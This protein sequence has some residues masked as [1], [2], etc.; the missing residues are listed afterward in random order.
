MREEA[1]KDQRHP[2]WCV[3]ASVFSAFI[4][5]CPLSHA[6]ALAGQIV[7]NPDNPAWLKYHQGSPFFM[8]GPGDP[9]GFLYRGTRNPDGTRTGDQMTLIDK[10]KGTGANAIYLMAVRSHGGDGDATH[11]PFVNNDPARGINM[12]VLDQWETWFTEMD[13]HGIVIFLFFYDDAA[14]IWDTGDTVGSTEEHFIHTLVNRF[15]HHRHLIWVVAEEYEE[16]YSAKR[17]S[18]IAAETRAA[19]DYDHPIAVHKLSGLDFSEFAGDPNI[20]QF[21]IQYNVS[22]PAALHNGMVTAWTNAAGRY[23]LNMAEAAG[24]GTGPTARKKSWAVAM[25]GAYVMALGWDIAT[26]P[27]NDLEDCGRLVRFMTS[28]DFTKMSP[29]DELK[30]GG[31]EYV[32]AKPGDSYIAYAS[33]LS[34]NIGLKSMTASVYDLTW[35]DITNGAFVTQP[36]VSVA[37][38]DQTWPKPSGIGQELAMAIKR[39][40]PDTLPPAAPSALRV[41]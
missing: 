18:N 14:R 37:A 4:G 3:V 24:Y 33:N 5:S 41:Q 34:G 32:L 38:G 19:D 2:I 7:V 40:T 17:V 1:M 20:D 13:N 39:T 28:T 15:E 30:H 36:G 12:A 10:L 21:A 23:N 27:I 22:S 6:A 8:C 9:E 11:N 25:G 35:Y 16:G 29:H 31:T 26:T